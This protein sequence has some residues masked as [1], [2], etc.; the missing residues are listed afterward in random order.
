M[1]SLLTAMQSGSQAKLGSQQYSECP[2]SEW[3]SSAHS[4]SSINNGQVGNVW[5]LITT[6]SLLLSTVFY[7][8][9]SVCMKNMLSID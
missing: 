7:K 8:G 4:I 5:D 3:G 2:V 9:I 6:P 1:N